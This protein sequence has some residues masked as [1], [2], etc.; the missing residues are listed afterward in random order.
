[1]TDEPLPEGVKDFILAEMYWKFC[2]PK[3]PD[4][5]EKQVV[6]IHASM[7]KLE[8]TFKVAVAVAGGIGMLLTWVGTMVRS[9]FATTGVPHT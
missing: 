2:D 3:N 1:M 8:T 7:A 4:C 5:I 9:V 6:Q